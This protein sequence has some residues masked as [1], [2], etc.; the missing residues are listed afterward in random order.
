MDIEALQKL[1]E[2]DPNAMSLLKEA[3]ET[4]N[5]AVWVVN[6][7][8]D[9]DHRPFNFDRHRYLIDIYNCDNRKIVVMKA[10]QMGLTIFLLLWSLHKIDTEGPIKLGFYFPTSDAIGKLSKD[11]LSPLMLKNERLKRMVN[12]LTFNDTIG[13]KQI[14]DSSLYLMHIGGVASKDSVPLDGLLF[15]EVRL[16]NPGDI[17]QTRERISHSDKKYELYVSTAGYPG[18]DINKRFL[19]GSQ[20]FWHSKCFC[21]P[22]PKNW[23][24]LPL[25]W[26]DCVIDAGD[27]VYYSCPFCNA[28]ISDP[29]NGAYVEHNPGAKFPSF[30]ISQ[31]VS[32]YISAEEILSF[33]HSTTNI[34]EFWRA[35][36]GLPFVDEENRPMSDA[37][38]NACINIGIPWSWT[39]DELGPIG[40]GVDQR[41]GINHIVIAQRV[42]E[43]KRIIHVEI[44]D[45]ACEDYYRPNII[46]KLVRVS[47]FVRLYELMEEF[48][49]DCCVLD[50]LPNANEA[51]E[52]GRAFPKRVYIA[53]YQSQKH[54]MRWSDKLG[55]D[56]PLKSVHE[57]AKY[58]YFVLL[59]RYL[60]IEA[61]LVAW[62]RR[63]V[64]IG[65][66]KGLV[67]R[68]RNKH[69]RYAASTIVLDYFLEH[70]KGIFRAKYNIKEDMTYSMKW[71][72]LGQDPHFL[73]AW[74]YCNAAL[75]RIKSNFQFMFVDDL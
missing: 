9:V 47:P 46:G 34:P 45:G 31:L 60:S 21:G 10:A 75:E 11:R 37:I 64:E 14:Q 29:Q 30:H 13:L 57:D 7:E 36:L 54:Q 18:H 39:N 65:D 25:N 32:D 22:E 20:N 71:V 4:D 51:K 16:M 38:F 17:D 43:K 61:A 41:S 1:L 26:P 2:S 5:L 48:N 52:F 12:P 23:V 67:Q 69:G 35:K 68:I 33:Y 44:V 72:N 74:N 28:K 66:P 27:S 62:I 19:E 6:H 55:K 8:I 3:V 53:Y 42:G 70:L 15:D 56:S 49:V 59:D 73:H 40:M 50:G 63:H 58:E 24:C